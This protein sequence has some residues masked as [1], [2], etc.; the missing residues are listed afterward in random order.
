MAI[1]PDPELRVLQLCVEEPFSSLFSFLIMLIELYFVFVLLPLRKHSL[2]QHVRYHSLGITLMW[3]WTYFWS[4]AFHFRETVLTERMD[5]FSSAIGW[6]YM[7]YSGVVHV[8]RVDD[9]RIKIGV[10][11]AMAVWAVRFI[12]YMVN[13]RFDYGYC[14]QSV[15][16]LVVV[17]FVM[18]ASWIAYQAYTRS[19]PWS[20]LAPCLLCHI[21][22]LCACPLELVDFLPIW[23]MLDGHSLWH[24]A[25]NIVAYA[26]AAFIVNETRFVIDN[27]AAKKLPV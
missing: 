11:G 27:E 22:I 18:Y 16:V 26:W 2:Y 25:G 1:N 8:F 15:A 19:R 10:A 17:H 12:D 3:V 21:V 7:V 9:I 5:Y 20:V 24:G 4:A 13:V 14:V 6:L 23:N